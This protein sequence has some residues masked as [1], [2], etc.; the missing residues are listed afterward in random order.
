MCI[1]PNMLADGQMVACRLCW[2]CRERRIE[3]WMGRGIAESKHAKAS[4][5]ITLT[6]GRDDRGVSDHMRAR[7]LTYSDVQK[8]F[9]LLR[10]HGYPM[11]Y[12][13]VGEYGSAKGRCHWH[14]IVFWKDRVP[15]HKLQTR[16]NSEF[17]PHGF[18]E[19]ENVTPSAIRYVCK[20]IQKDSKDIHQQSHMAM[21]KK[22]LIGASYFRE[23]AGRYVANGLAPQKPYY[24]F[25]EARNKQ[26][27]RIR[28]RMS[29]A[30]LSLFLQSFLDQW[31]KAHPEKPVP[32]SELVEDYIDGLVPEDLE[33][34]TEPHRGK[35]PKP[36]EKDLRSFM[37]PDRVF[38]DERKN[39]YY[40]QFDY[41]QTPWYWL[42]NDEGY[43]E[44]LNGIKERTARPST[45]SAVL[46][47]PQR[48]PSPPR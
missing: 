18:S 46:R 7:V 23:L 38:F 39:C 10:R 36:E 3:D 45:T 28:F 31:S 34:R 37:D 4:H 13:A 35:V 11:R 2:Q 16:F 43:C 47:A 24:E 5:F 30:T 6:Y 27:K 8:F 15:P 19:W 20:Y 44:W 25:D 14:L 12:I 41:G 29:G 22:P 9:K 32:A 48:G 21:S 17:W 40:Y 33:I 1:R 26:G 42:R